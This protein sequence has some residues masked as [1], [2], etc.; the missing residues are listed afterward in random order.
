MS[1]VNSTLHT[2]S[3]EGHTFAELIRRVARVRGYAPEVGVN[4]GL[5]EDQED[6]QRVKDAVNMGLSRFYAAHDWT[7]LKPRVQIEMVVA[8]DGPFNIDG[9]SGRYRLPAGIQGTPQTDWSYL[10]TESLLREVTRTSF[11]RIRELYAGSIDASGFPQY[12]ATEVLEP[13]DEEDTQG[14]QVAVWPRPQ[15]AYRLEA[16]FFIMPGELQQMSDR[17]YGGRFHD[18][19]IFL[20]AVSELRRQDDKDERR[21]ARA[22][23]DYERQLMLSIQR[24]LRNR[25]TSVGSFRDPTIGT[26]LRRDDALLLSYS[27]VTMVSGTSIG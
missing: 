21:V 18:H 8:G 23:A 13:N 20:A 22:D 14:W 16:Q 10:D 3:T 24:D 11:S 1:R 26:Q 19:A 6:L 4:D 27:G 15:S 2:V 12:A 17:P 7:F 5:P 25:P 9:D